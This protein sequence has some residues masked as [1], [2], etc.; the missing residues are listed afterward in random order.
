M[1]SK[2]QPGTK[3]CLSDAGMLIFFESFLGILLL[4]FAFSSTI[5]LHKLVQVF[6]TLQLPVHCFGTLDTLKVICLIL[7]HTFSFVMPF[8][9][10]SEHRKIM[11]SLIINL[12]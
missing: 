8:S 7:V 3:N 6:D 5:L 9:Y 12:S 1:E 2:T 11:T 4:D 10:E